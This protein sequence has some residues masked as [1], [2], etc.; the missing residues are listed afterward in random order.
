MEDRSS[1]HLV[2]GGLLFL[3]FALVVALVFVYTRAG[4]TTTGGGATTTAQVANVPPTVDSVDIAYAD[5]GPNLDEASGIDLTLGT[6]KQVVISGTISDANG[7]DTQGDNTYGDVSGVSVVFYRSGVANADSCTADMNNCY[8]AQLSDSSCTLS[9]NSGTTVHYACTLNLQYF[10]DSTQA[11]G[12]YP[13][14]NWV[15]KVTA[16][17]LSSTTGTLSGTTNVNALLALNIPTSIAYGQFALGATTTAAAAEAPGTNRVMTITQE[18]NILADVNVKGSD[19]TCDAL[20]TIPVANEAWA[21]SV[22]AYSAATPLTASDVNTGLDVNYQTDDNFSTN[23]ST[24]DLYW[25]IK[26]PST[27]VRGVCTGANTISI[28][29]H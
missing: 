11:G 22:V 2:L 4:N 7:T 21:T 23:P 24:K 10:T 9:G 28:I 20:G 27:G 8:R 16:T 29:A 18:G 13:T 5:N 3:V 19:M 26:I 1:D 17:D 6:T 25:H 12:E 15:A 14:D